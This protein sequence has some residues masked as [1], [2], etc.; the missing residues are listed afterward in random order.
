MG[1]KTDWWPPPEPEPAPESAGGWR[2]PSKLWCPKCQT[3]GQSFAPPGSSQKGRIIRVDETERPGMV[4]NHL[5]QMVLFDLPDD[6]FRIVSPAI[7]AVSLSDARRIAS[8]R[9]RPDGLQVL[10]VGDRQTV[11]PGLRELGLPLV[12]LDS[13]G[14]RID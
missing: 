9:I 5:I 6:Y 1:V 7:N 3:P 12:T 8:E 4:V 11:E 10:V 13:E 14:V 2:I